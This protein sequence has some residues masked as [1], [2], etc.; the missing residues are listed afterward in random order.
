MFILSNGPLFVLLQIEVMEDRHDSVF[1]PQDI[2]YL[3]SDASTGEW[4]VNF[5]PNLCLFLP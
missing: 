3:T 5:E 1:D 4:S 2:V